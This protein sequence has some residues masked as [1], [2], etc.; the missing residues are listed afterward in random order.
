MPRFVI[1]GKEFSK[2]GQ[3]TW[4]GMNMT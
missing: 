3:K 1:I 2:P 4:N